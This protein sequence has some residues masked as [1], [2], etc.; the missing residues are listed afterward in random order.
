M[1]NHQSDCFFKPPPSRGRRG[2]GRRE[3][4][5]TEPPPASGRE[6][7]GRLNKP[8]NGPT[9]HDRLLARLYLA[10]VPRVSADVVKAV[11]QESFSEQEAEETLQM[12]AVA[13]FEAEPSTLNSTSPPALS[14]T[15]PSAAAAVPLAS[16]GLPDEPSAEEQV[17][18]LQL[19][20]ADAISPGIVT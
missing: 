9:Q 14:S 17:A 1:S 13:A 10:Y 3:A 7:S 6:T 15:P 19:M 16:A 20:F 11:V 4:A 8:N 2:G 5:A 18:F 12:L